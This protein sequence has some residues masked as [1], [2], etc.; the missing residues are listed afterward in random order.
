MTQAAIAALGDISGTA[1]W[2]ARY[3]ALETERGAP[4]FRDPWAARLAGDRGRAIVEHLPAAKSYA[5]VFVMRTVILDRIITTQLT[6][7]GCDTVINLASGLD[8]RAFRLE[9]PRDV[10]WFDVDNAAIHEHKRGVLHGAAPHCR[11]E[12]ISAD[13]NDD[14][15]RRALLAELGARGKKVLVITE[16]LLQYLTDTQ[17]TTLARDLHDVPAVHTWVFD[18][19]TPAVMGLVKRLWNPSLRAVNAP[20]QFGPKEGTEFFRASGWRE[21]ERVALSSEAMQHHRLPLAVRL[22]YAFH[23][24][25]S[26]DTYNGLCATGIAR[27]EREA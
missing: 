5:W 20:L 3:R 2:I 11:W 7:G 14:G 8:T 25:L 19:N 21:A 12:A 10:Q 4:L 15:R 23:L 26:P 13:L 9:L 16:G 1:Y 24:V 27:L 6:R 17:V 22:F 18:L